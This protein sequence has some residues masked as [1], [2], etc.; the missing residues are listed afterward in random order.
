[1]DLGKLAEKAKGL[2]AK[3]GGTDSLKKD[4]EELKDIAGGNGSVTDKATRRRRG[5][6]GSRRARRR[7]VEHREAPGESSETARAPSI[8]RWRPAG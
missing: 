5:G 1:M 8:C 4:A 2:V 3:R 6:Q 7:P